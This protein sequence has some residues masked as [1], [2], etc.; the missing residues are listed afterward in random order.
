MLRGVVAGGGRFRVV[1]LLANSLRD[2]CANP[3]C[4]VVQPPAVGQLTSIAS[5]P[6]R[7]RLSHLSAPALLV[8]FGC[9]S[10]PGK[11][12]DFVERTREIAARTGK[13]TLAAD[14]AVMRLSMSQKEY[15]QVDEVLVRWLRAA[16]ESGRFDLIHFAQLPEVTE[17]ARQPRL[18]V[19]LNALMR[20]VEAG[21]AL[22]EGEATTVAR[23]YVERMPAWGTTQDRRDVLAVGL[24][25]LADSLLRDPDAFSRASRVRSAAGLYELAVQLATREVTNT[26]SAGG[27]SVG[28]ASVVPQDPVAKQHDLELEL[29]LN[30]AAFYYNHRDLVTT[31]GRTDIGK[32]RFL[33]LVRNTSGDPATA[34]HPPGPLSEDRWRARTGFVGSEQRIHY[35]GTLGLIFCDNTWLDGPE[36]RERGIRYLRNAV[37]IAKRTG[38]RHPHLEARLA[39]VL[40]QTNRPVPSTNAYIGATRDYFDSNRVRRGREVGFEGLERGYQTREDL[41]DK[42]CELHEL[43]YPRQG[44]YIG[45]SFGWTDGG[46]SANEFQDEVNR[47]SPA[48]RNVSISIDDTDVGYKGFVGYRFANPFAVELAWTGLEGPDSSVNAPAVDANLLGDIGQLHPLA[49]RG[50]SLSIVG[51]PYECGRL[52]TFAKL[53]IWYWEADVEVDLSGG[54]VVRRRP[55][56]FDFVG[57]VGMT[58]RLVDRLGARVEYER[59]FHDDDG[60]DL[61][62]VGLSYTF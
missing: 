5:Q 38:D 15:V 44:V 12:P 32:Q 39:D 59:Y 48:G 41:D 37:E 35:W 6:V 10:A 7:I 17:H 58:Y 28:G 54:N 60:V 31:D 3:S 26:R 11:D 30:L 13:A 42:L 50:P 29:A 22:D 18:L 56:G 16:G 33:R 23:G 47:R 57:G 46:G 21:V 51:H 27:S 1:C 61:L 62:S 9:S 43:L 45:G 4:L 34:G 2:A 53:G 52:S 36:D 25:S 19:E 40:Y 49:G 24:Q 8:L 20:V 55:T 14:E